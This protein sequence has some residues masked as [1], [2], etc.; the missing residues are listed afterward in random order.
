MPK[1]KNRRKHS[2]VDPTVQ[3][4]LVLRIALYW[5]V[6]MIDVVVALSDLVASRL[7]GTRFQPQS[8]RN[9]VRV[10]AIACG[11]SFV[12]AAGNSGHHPI[13]QPVC[14]AI[15][16][17]AAV[18]AATRARRIRNANYVPPH[19]LLAGTCRRFQRRLGP[20]AGPPR[21]GRSRVG[22]GEGGRRHYCLTRIPHN[23]VIHAR[24]S[25]YLSGC[26][27]WRGCSPRRSK[28]MGW[29]VRGIAVG[30]KCRLK[31]I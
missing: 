24:G 7:S 26:G 15:G 2:F 14:W 30:Q 5:V 17:F 25:F 19:R 8:G 18:D 29:P 27:R 28:T 3:G 12:A 6:F 16:A 20:C 22:G 31:R 10:R 11:V 13:Q 4:G 23:R 21:R 1:M 9:V